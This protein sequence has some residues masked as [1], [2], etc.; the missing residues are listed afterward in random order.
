MLARINEDLEI[1]LQ[2]DRRKLYLLKLYAAAKW[3]IF[4]LKY[5]SNHF[6]M[7]R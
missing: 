6:N 2:L 7:A 5:L 3:L 1:E 4:F